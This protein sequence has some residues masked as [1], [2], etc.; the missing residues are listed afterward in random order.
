MLDPHTLRGRLAIAYASALTVGL[1]VFALVAT[2]LLDT[3][4]RSTLDDRLRTA[5]EAATSIVDTNDGKVELDENDRRQF[6]QIVGDALLGAVI[7]RDGTILATNAPRV[8]TAV[9]TI[10][11]S[12][13][14]AGLQ[15]TR[16]GSGDVRVIVRTV[17]AAGAVVG[18]VVVW[19]STEPIAQLDISVAVGFVLLI[20]ILAALAAFFGGLIARNALRPLESMSE[21]ASE[22]E[23][24]DLSRRLALAEAPGEL[25]RFVAAFNRML[26]RLEDAFDRQRRFT[27]DASHELRTPLSVIRAEADLALM[28]E[29]SGVEYRATLE[30]IARE[31]DRLEAL[32]QDL[33]GAARVDSS[34]GQSTA[35][36]DLGTIAAE[37]V[38]RLRF[39]TTPSGS[40]IRTEVEAVEVAG[41]ASAL[42]RVVTSLVEN[43]LKHGRPQGTIDVIVRPDGDV[44]ELIVRDN[45]AGFSPEALRFGLER[46]WRGSAA[47]PTDGAGLGL[48]IARA[49]VEAC[50]GTIALSNNSGAQ[51]TVR[52]PLADQRSVST[53]Q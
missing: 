46:F 12:A 20:P 19:R 7:L 33:L 49:I 25:E 47:R 16:V 37:T 22:I 9:R 32:T 1:V 23:A 5:S 36:T 11:T 39:L 44:A 52:L 10:A 18:A 6:A 41:E 13:D 14:V 35:R 4:Q 8:P 53:V 42:R 30:A 2:L 24:H 38:E 51:V 28:R 34:G 45:G 21:V 50:G 3:I 29:R 40:T 27:A 15:T 31:A 48:A 43:A 26:D 17:T